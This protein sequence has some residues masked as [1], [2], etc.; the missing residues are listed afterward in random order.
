MDN[1]NFEKD[2]LKDELDVFDIGKSLIRSEVYTIIGPI[3]CL[4][5]I[6]AIIVAFDTFK[7]NKLNKEIVALQDELSELQYTEKKES[8]MLTKMS[9]E[10]PTTINIEKIEINQ[11]VPKDDDISAAIDSYTD[12]DLDLL[13]HLISAEAGSD[14]C[15][16]DLMLYTGSVVLNRIKHESFPDDLYSVIHQ[17]GQ[18]SCVN[19]GSINK[20]PTERAC[21]AAQE[22]LENGSILPENVVFQAQFE[23]G[24]GVY[25]KEQ[26]MYF[27]YK[28][29][30]E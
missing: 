3:C 6:L 28:G 26:N 24:D 22:L 17:P 7:I 19:S 12:D 25:I 20:K 15:T 21:L 1:N 16:Y 27:C 18:Y 23:Q 30:I 8:E 5:A 9:G 4:F 14:S 29:E 11:M 10:Q 13:S 2:E